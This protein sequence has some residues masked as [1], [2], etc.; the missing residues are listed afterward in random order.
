MKSQEPAGTTASSL[1]GEGGVPEASLATQ[2]VPALPS[3]TDTP[4]HPHCLPTAVC[5]S[6]TQSTFVQSQAR[7]TPHLPTSALLPALEKLPSAVL[8]EILPSTLCQGSRH[9]P[10]PA[11]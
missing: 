11:C 4:P 6:A 5:G 2:R 9:S 8:P 10:A 3:H 1:P 7:L